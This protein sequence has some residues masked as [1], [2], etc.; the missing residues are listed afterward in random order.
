MMTRP[1]EIFVRR[2]APGGRFKEARPRN[3]CREPADRRR[4][5]AALAVQIHPEASE[6][7]DF[8]RGIRDSVLAKLTLRVRYQ[9][10]KN[11]LFNVVA[12]QDSGV[13]PHD[14]AVDPER[15]RLT[16]EQQQI[17]RTAVGHCLEPL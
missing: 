17:A 9:L 5:L 11:K 6:G 1:R 15:R 3:G 7:G 4:R 14:A 16:R 10:W 13:A 8:Q 2:P 12:V